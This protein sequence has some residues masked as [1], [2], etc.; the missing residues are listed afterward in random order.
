MALYKTGTLDSLRS[1]VRAKSGKIMLVR[2]HEGVDH[3]AGVVADFE[4]DEE[5]DIIAWRASRG[6]QAEGD[7]IKEIRIMEDE[8][9]DYSYYEV[10]L[11]STAP[12]TL[13]F[14]EPLDPT[15]ENE[16]ESW[17]AQKPL[18]IIKDSLKQTI[19][20][21][22]EL[23]QASPR[24]KAFYFSRWTR[25]IPGFGLYPVGIVVASKSRLMFVG[26]PGEEMRADS[27]NKSKGG[28]VTGDPQSDLLRLS[29]GGQMTS[30]SVPEPIMASDFQDASNQAMSLVMI[31]RERIDDGLSR[32]NLVVA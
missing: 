3:K 30:F 17:A 27:W 23:P 11:A 2:D 25:L 31:A 24:D 18:L 13:I 29:A 19:A 5:N 22:A 9:G 10:D 8:E 26:A 1:F 20:D 21:I 6:R 16:R 14:R 32:Q 12:L 7:R 15:E 28:Q 4:F